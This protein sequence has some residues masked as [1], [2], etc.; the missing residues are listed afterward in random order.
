MVV[1]HVDAL[2]GEVR[3]LTAAYKAGGPA[4]FRAFRDLMQL[5][6]GITVLADGQ[7]VRVVQQA[8]RQQVGALGGPTGPTCPVR[9]RNGRWLR[10]AVDLYL[11]PHEGG[12]RLKVRKS[13]FQYQGG[14]GGQQEVFRF[15][16]LREPGDAPDHPTAH[17]NVHGTLDVADVLPAGRT[18]A[19]VHFPTNR[20]SLEA[21]IRL[22]THDF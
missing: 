19:R 11:Q 18:L 5:L 3:S 20:I 10:V 4:S 15:D 21:V 14:E 6:L 1:D 22:L 7:Y 9:L 13:S 16:Y 2:A 17:L 8:G 12:T